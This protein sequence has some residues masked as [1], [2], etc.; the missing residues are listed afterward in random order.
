[1]SLSHLAPRRVRSPH[2]VWFLMMPLW[3]VWVGIYLI[4]QPAHF[5][6]V[7]VMGPAQDAPGGANGGNSRYADSSSLEVGG[8]KYSAEMTTHL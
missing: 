8:G 5:A 6:S 3:L 4:K 2:Q 7:P 1:M